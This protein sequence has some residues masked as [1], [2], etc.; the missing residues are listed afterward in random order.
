[1]AQSESGSSIAQAIEDG[2]ADVNRANPGQPTER[3]V[4]MD[5][6]NQTTECDGMSIVGIWLWIRETDLAFQQ[7]GQKRIVMQSEIESVLVAVIVNPK[8]KCAN[9]DADPRLNIKN[10][11]KEGFLNIDEEVVVHEEKAN[12]CSV[13]SEG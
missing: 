4:I 11:I 1:M 8:N 12:L 13:L 2:F 3:G 6:V 10:N 5:W 9:R 7:V